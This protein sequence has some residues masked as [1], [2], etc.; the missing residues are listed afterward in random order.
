LF[1]N[2]RTG[3]LHYSFQIVRIIALSLVLTFSLHSSAQQPFSITISDEPITAMPGI[4]SFA[5]AENNGKWLFIGGRTNGLHGFLTPFAFPTSYV[6]S[7]ITVVDPVLNQN[8]TASTSALSDS[9]REPITSTNMEYYKDGNTLYMIGGYGWKNS[10]NDFITFPTLT[11]IDV[12]GL[13]NAVLTGTNIDSYFRQI[14][15]TNLA[16]AGA[17]LEKMDTTFYLVFGHLFNGSYHQVDS[18]NIQRYSNAIH[19]FQIHDDG[20]N[21]SISNF[22]SAVDTTNFHRRDYNLVPQIFPDRQFGFTAFSG[23]FRY[24]INLPFLNSIDIKPSLISMNNS[25]TQNLNNYESAVMPV[26]DSIYNTMHS[27]FFGGMSLYYVDTATQLQVMDTL[28]PFVNTISRVQRNSDSTMTEYKLPAEM[29]GYYGSNAMFI[30][31]PSISSYNSRIINLNALS[32]ITKV[33]YI[34]GGITSPDRN[35]AATGAEV[36]SA[37]SRVFAVYID[38]NPS[39]VNETKLDNDINDFI[40]Y[41]DASGNLHIEFITRTDGKVKLELFDSKGALLK[42]IFE[43]V[44]I[45][46][47][48]NNFTFQSGASSSAF[49]CRITKNTFSRTIKFVSR[50]K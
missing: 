11:A 15:D 43:G 2:K 7:Q 3:I 32:G 38:K 14:S 13:I 8:W 28:V 41:P 16:I 35:I 6:N 24:G 5:F 45:A 17:H 20:T 36:S 22:Q 4:H 21:I 40:I 27:V 1:R 18:F 39:G 9:I 19:T 48:K 26:Y 50:G 33:G 12:S 10:I 30:P 46:G 31:L 37:S 34:V 49:F 44:T 25:F 42:N 29:P 23:V 47:Q